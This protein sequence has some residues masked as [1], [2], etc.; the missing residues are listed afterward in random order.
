[1][2]DLGTIGSLE[3]ECFAPGVSDCVEIS[4][5]DDTIVEGPE[6]FDVTLDMDASNFPSVEVSSVPLH[7]TIIDE[8]G[9][10]VLKRCVSQFPLNLHWHC[11]S[12]PVQ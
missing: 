7:L 8:E 5:L 2:E 10:V 11:S 9:E 1:M 3:Y 6:G 12:H 4:A